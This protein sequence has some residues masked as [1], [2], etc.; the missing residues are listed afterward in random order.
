MLF[1]EWKEAGQEPNTIRDSAF[2]DSQASAVVNSPCFT[3]ME[4]TSVSFEP[5][6][7]PLPCDFRLIYSLRSPSLTTLHLSVVQTLDIVYRKRRVGKEDVELLEVNL[8]VKE[9]E[10]TVEVVVPAPDYAQ[11]GV[12]SEE[13]TNVAMLEGN[14]QAA[15]LFLAGAPVHCTLFATQTIEE[16]KQLIRVLVS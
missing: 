16:A 6:V 4:V 1:G 8:E 14:S 12:S 13:L 7:S 3:D 2:L 15:T 11:F 10:S 5:A 9:G